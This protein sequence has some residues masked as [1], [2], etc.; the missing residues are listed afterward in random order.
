MLSDGARRTAT[1]KRLFW[2]LMLMLLF[3]SLS[4]SFFALSA[5][6]G[7][8]VWALFG[9]GF[10]IIFLASGGLMDQARKRLPVADKRQGFWLLQFFGTTFTTEFF[11]AALIAWIMGNRTLSAEPGYQVLG[12]IIFLLL[13]GVGAQGMMATML[14]YVESHS[15]RENDKRAARLVREAAH[16]EPAHGQPAL[17]H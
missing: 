5:Y 9:V 4:M 11:V 3:C 14:F 1:V 12:L 16:G 17:A 8:W 10:G 15:H 7:E 13:L 2:M 6:E